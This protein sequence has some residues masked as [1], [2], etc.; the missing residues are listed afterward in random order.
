MIRKEYNMSKIDK[1]IKKL[2]AKPKD[3]TYE[4]AK[5]ILNLVLLNIIREKHQV[6]E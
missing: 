4:E 1:A 2:K 3:L 5:M 6:Q